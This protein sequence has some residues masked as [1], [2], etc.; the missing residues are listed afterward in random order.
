[1][2]LGGQGHCDQAQEAAVGGRP[3]QGQPGVGS[4]IGQKQASFSTYGEE[5]LKNIRIIF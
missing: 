5:K 3:T 2:L 1:M 4:D